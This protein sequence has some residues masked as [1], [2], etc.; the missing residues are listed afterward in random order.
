MLKI[1]LNTQEMNVYFAKTRGQSE[2]VDTKAFWFASRTKLI[3][4]REH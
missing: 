2:V 4:P 1:I 3:A